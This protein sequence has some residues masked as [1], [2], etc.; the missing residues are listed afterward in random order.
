MMGILFENLIMNNLLGAHPLPSFA[1]ALIN[2]RG[3]TFQIDCNLGYIAGFSEMLVSSTKH[4]I[5]LLG[6]LPAFWG[7]ERS[8]DCGLK[9][10]SL[11]GKWN[12]KTAGWKG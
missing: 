9:T 1:Q 3:L 4:S 8:P 5:N 7:M 6:G 11:S 12:G 10:D 2:K